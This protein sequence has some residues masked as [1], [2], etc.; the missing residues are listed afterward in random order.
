VRDFD[1]IVP[2]LRDEAFAPSAETFLYDHLSPRAVSTPAGWAYVKIS[3]GCSHECSFCAIPRIKG[4][5][6]SRPAASIV[7]EVETLAGRG[8][9]EINLISQ[10][11]TYYRRDR[12]RSDGLA[13]LL[14][15]LARVGGIQWIRVLYGYPEEVTDSLLEAIRIPKVCPYFDIPF[16]HADSGILRRMGRSMNGRRAL[17]LLEKIRT[18]VPGAAIRT[19]IIVGFPG[20]GRREF[21]ALKTFVRDARFDHLGVFAYSAEEGTPAFGSGD[22]VP[23]SVKEER[24]ET[25]LQIQ[26]EISAALLRTCVGQTLEVLFEGRSG[27][28]SR[29]WIG[30]TRR[31]APEVDGVVLVRASGDRLEN[32]IQRVKITSSGTYD[33]RGSIA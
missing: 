32:P 4:S 8:V 13:R 27:K 20:E 30:R 31:Q 7:K 26:A 11:S 16:Q 5:Y 33:L 15:S 6:R 25:I 12:G 19:S 18:R 22:P 28:N 23:L 14:E 21:E 1:K 2:L 17:R 10:D 29:T 24:R 9:R 3:E